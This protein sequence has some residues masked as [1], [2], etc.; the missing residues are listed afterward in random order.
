MSSRRQFITQTT[1]AIASAAFVPQLAAQHPNPSPMPPLSTNQ[2]PWD[3][4]YR[5]D[6]K[7]FGTDLSASIAE[8]VASGF[9][10]LE[11]NLE[12]VAMV[13]DYVKTMQ[14]LGVT[15]PTIYVNSV[16]HDHTANAS[17]D[18][19][20]RIATRA[21][22]L[23][24]TSIVVTNPRPVRW[25]GPENK[26][27]AEIITQGKALEKLGAAL[28]REGITLAYHNHDSEFRLGAR[29][30]HHMH[31]ATN[32]AHVKFCLDAHWV[33]R[34]SGDSEVA[35]F[36]TVALYGSRVVELH[37]R[38]STNGVWTE[39]FAPTGDINYPRLLS[40]LS[41]QGIHPFITLEQAVEDGSPH[42]LNS[43]EAHRASLV[44][45]QKLMSEP[46]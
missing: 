18:E 3:T 12:S 27:D 43:V 32:P 24:Q 1:A 10:A 21:R 44:G 11:P 19:V 4:F 15:M 20:L 30:Y 6:G 2:Y 8:V 35:V 7:N 46:A 37:L 23:A 42:T 25:G 31:N 26:S 38:Q 41:A 36:D 17:I 45:L 16:L 40:E 28:H 29:E 13:D 5:R 39:S 14:P 22:D 9:T 33:Y 34:G